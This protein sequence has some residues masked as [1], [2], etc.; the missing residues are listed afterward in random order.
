MSDDISEEGKALIEG[1]DPLLN[2]TFLDKYKI[3]SKIGEGSFG[4]IYKAEYENKYYALKTENK[5]YGPDMLELESTLMN[6]LRCGK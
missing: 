2:K 4:K 3:I 6:Y 1:G 5:R